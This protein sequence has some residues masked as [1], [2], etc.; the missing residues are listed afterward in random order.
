MT[1]RNR[2]AAGIAAFPH[3]ALALAVCFLF[4]AA[5]PGLALSEIK[6]EELPAVDT[7]AQT[8]VPD[9]TI[10]QSGGTTPATPAPATQAPTPAAPDDPQQQT[11]PDD[12]EGQVPDDDVSAG[13]DPGAPL[14]DI[15]Y[16]LSKLPEP[17][18]HTR[19]QIIE[20]AK[21]GDIEKLRPLLGLGTEQTQLSLGGIEGDPIKF[22]RELSGDSGGQEILAIIEE[23]LSAGY[24]HMDPGTE[25]DFYV[26]PYFFAIPL[27][28]LTPAQRVELFKIV[29]AGDYEDM[30]TY[31]AYIFYRIGI[32]PEG[33]W[34]FFIAGD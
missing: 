5:G 1:P 32:T 29:T 11:A 13:P 15:L 34:S 2:R 14:P 21:S 24:V 33:R 8:P 16:D 10:P 3:R 26:W 18:Q 30:K 7:P 6:R 27:D 17:V 20:A 25:N 31:G 22:L 4:L 28:K 12:E 23:V 19:A 9:Q